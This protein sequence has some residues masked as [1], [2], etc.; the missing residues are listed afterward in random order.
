MQVKDF[1]GEATL[2]FV[3]PN[4]L[5]L[6]AFI[7]HLNQA[8]V[9]TQAALRQAGS[10]KAL[11][12]KSLDL[13]T[14]QLVYDLPVECS[15]VKQ[16]E[17]LDIE[18]QSLPLVRVPFQQEDLELAKQY[19]RIGQDPM[20]YVLMPGRRLR[21][22]EAPQADYAKGLRLTFYPRASKMQSLDDEPLGIPEEI[23]EPLLAKALN[24][25]RQIGGVTLKDQKAFLL[26]L[27]QMQKMEGDYLY[28]QDAE[29]PPQW[30]ETGYYS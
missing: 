9:E 16:A 3:E 10:E 8:T 12:Q 6:S 21:L 29:T 24:R 14:G 27:Q 28:P 1:I 4:H 22:T 25:T 23:H 2:R 5:W 17:R 30:V 7:G 15:D 11:V 18:A 19:I 13:V 26:W 20:T